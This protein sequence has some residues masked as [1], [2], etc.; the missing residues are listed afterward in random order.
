MCIPYCYDMDFLWLPFR[1]HMVIIWLSHANHM[2]SICS[3]FIWIPYDYHVGPIWALMKSMWKTC[4]SIT[5][6]PCGNRYKTSHVET[7]TWDPYIFLIGTVWISYGNHVEIIWILYGN[8]NGNNRV[9]AINLVDN[10]RILWDS[11]MV[12]IPLETYGSHPVPTWFPY[13]TW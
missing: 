6:L 1:S 12:T 8:Y 2:N 13:G 11:H 10:A 5:W 3:L 4:F 9:V 7:S